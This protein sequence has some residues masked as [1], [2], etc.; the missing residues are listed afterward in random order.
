MQQCSCLACLSVPLEHHVLAATEPACCNPWSALL[1]TPEKTPK[2]AWLLAMQVRPLLDRHDAGLPER[3]GGE[4]CVVRVLPPHARARAHRQR[5]PR[6]VLRHRQGAPTLAAAGMHHCVTVTCLYPTANFGLPSPS[7]N[8]KWRNVRLACVLKG[9][10]ESR[11]EHYK[12]IWQ[13]CVSHM[14]APGWSNEG[15]CLGGR[16]GTAPSCSTG[17]WA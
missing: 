3:S 8:L 7:E 4:L 12:F 14:P 13:N 17:T 10:S 11:S 5:H 6:L 2:L 1:C 15:K 16:W 9:L